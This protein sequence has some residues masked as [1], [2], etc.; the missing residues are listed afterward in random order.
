MIAEI[1]KT[2]KLFPITSIFIV[3]SIAFSTITWF[4]AF[5]DILYLFV[6]DESKIL[7]GQIYRLVTPIF[8][9]FPVMGVFFAHLGMN[10]IMFYQFAKLIESKQGKIFLTLFI[11]SSGIFSNLAQAYFSNGIFG[12][13][14]GVVYALLGYLFLIK[15]I[16][17]KS[18]YNSF[19]VIRLDKIMIFLIVF[20][21]LGFTGVLGDGIGNSA[22]LAGFIFGVIAAA[23]FGFVGKLK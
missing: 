18:I 22:H 17:A 8:L 10:M 23:I 5:K 20:L 9:H 12:G 2:F 15:K 13:M 21:G 1:K 16:N 4:G 19:E 6:Y 3:L 14:S 11:I 7:S